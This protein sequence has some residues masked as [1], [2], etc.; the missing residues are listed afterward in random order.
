MEWLIKREGLRYNYYCDEKGAVYHL[1]GNGMRAYAEER[2]T[3][4]PVHPLY[5]HKPTDRTMVMLAREIGGLVH[6]D[7]LDTLARTMFDIP[8]NQLGYGLTDLKDATNPTFDNLRFISV[9]SEGK[10]TRITDQFGSRKFI[11]VADDKKVYETTSKSEPV[12]TALP[13]RSKYETEDALELEL[14]GRDR[15]LIAEALYTLIEEK[16]YSAAQALDTLILEDSTDALTMYL[17]GKDI[18]RKS[19]DE[20]VDKVGQEKGKS[21]IGGMVN[22][23]CTF[24]GKTIYLSYK[25]GQSYV[26]EQ[27]KYKPL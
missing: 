25:T 1:L 4:F 9:D 21:I 27:G 5:P 12:D 24:N 6:L 14:N 22:S 7:L 2:R 13:N 3:T 19:S 16:G 10:V 18:V 15:S 26:R 8:S 17:E 11:K 23:G 20:T